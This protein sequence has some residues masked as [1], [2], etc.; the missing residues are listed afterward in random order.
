MFQRRLVPFAASLLAAVTVFAQD[1]AP[2]PYGSM[3][4]MEVFGQF[5][6]VFAKSKSF[7]VT[8]QAQVLGAAS[9]NI[10]V[11]MAR[12]N[13]GYIKSPSVEIYLN[14]KEITVYRPRAHTYYKLPQSK[15]NLEKAFSA[16]EYNVWRIF[17][18]PKAYDNVYQIRAAGSLVRRGMSMQVIEIQGDVDSLMTA[19]LYTDPQDNQLRQAQFV[20]EEPKRKTVTLIDVKDFKTDVEV[21]PSDFEFQVPTGVTYKKP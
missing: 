17:L 8:Y 4:A 16:S 13:V 14:G 20:R 12:P 19:T 11:E 7:K 18:D 3:R 5:R 1:G 2:A 21:N 10:E 15:T 6:D 9:Q